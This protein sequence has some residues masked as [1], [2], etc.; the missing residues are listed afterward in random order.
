M[1]HLFHRQSFCGFDD[2]DVILQISLLHSNAVGAV[3]HAVVCST[4]LVYSGVIQGM[5]MNKCWFG[6]RADLFIV[7]ASLFAVCNTTV[8][9]TAI[10]DLL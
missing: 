7:N 2:R 4:R 10:I 6:L 5:K 1:S 8:I 9:L 3:S